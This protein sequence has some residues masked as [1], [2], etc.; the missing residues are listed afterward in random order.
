MYCGK[1]YYGP[2]GV[3]Y[4]TP[5]GGSQELRSLAPRMAL[6]E[7][8]QRPVYIWTTHL[9]CGDCHIGRAIIEDEYV[10]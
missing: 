8:W 7:I 10:A 5:E 4:M 2:I 9:L 6:L 1:E 3:S